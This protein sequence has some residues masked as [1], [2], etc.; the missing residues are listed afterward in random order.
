MG[1][2][3]PC[4]RSLQAPRMT[5]AYLETNSQMEADFF[6]NAEGIRERVW[7]PNK[8][9]RETPTRE[10]VMH[11]VHID[12]KACQERMRQLP[13][14]SLMFI[15]KDCREAIEAQP[16]GPKAGYYAD[17]MSYAGMEI[18]RRQKGK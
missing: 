2:R 17:E 12:H 10:T 3:H 4:E 1:R 6:E 8:T 16:E 14:A 7:G 15:I 11:T 18:T 13:F 5:V 9:P